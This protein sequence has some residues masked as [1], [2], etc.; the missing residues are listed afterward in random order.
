MPKIDI[1]TAP[2]RSGSGYPAP[3][4]TPC[5]KRHRIALGDAGGLAQFGAHM[6]TLEPGVWSS[7]RHHHSAEDEFVYILSGMPTFIDNDGEQILQP[8]D[9][10]A[11]PAGDGNAHH[12]INRTDKD[13]VY[14]VIG[15][16]NPEQDNGVYPDINLAIPANGTP[17][18][19]FTR[20]DG[21]PY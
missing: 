13:V 2:R 3:F 1:Q 11:H 4:D 12:M 5:F 21:T 15:S 20:K 14:L 7:Q 16:R 8:G 17:D 19:V 18:R 10:T 6:L 9:C